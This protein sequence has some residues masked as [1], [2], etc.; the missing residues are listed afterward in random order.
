[1]LQ[2]MLESLSSRAADL[3]YAL[4]RLR[5]AQDLGD[6]QEIVRTSVRVLAG[7]DGATFVLREGDWC[8]YADEDAMSPLWKGQRF[9]MRDCISGWAMTNER[10]ACIPDITFDERIPQDAYRPT[11]VRSLVMVPIGRAPALAAIGAYWARTQAPDEEVVTVLE[12]L[13]A[14]VA[15]AIGRIGI[16]DA[17]IAPVL[18]RPSP[19]L[20]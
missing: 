8:F 4:D 7:A 1:M 14:G 20:S 13:A 6:V 11:F 16:D 18:A 3:S 12:D 19:N 10:I 9:P 5:K 17:P 15:E 2:G